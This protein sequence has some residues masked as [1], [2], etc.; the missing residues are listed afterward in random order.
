NVSKF[1]RRAENGEMTIDW[2][3]M[4]RVVR[5]AVRFLDDVIEM[6]P[7][8]LP[9]I[10]K[11]VKDNRRI[12]LGI[13]GWADLLFLLGIPYDGKA[14]TDL[15]DRLMSFV[16]GSRT[17]SRPSSPRNAGRSRTGSI[18]STRTSGR[19]GTPPSPRSR[20]PARSR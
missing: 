20:P 2:D 14:A 10:D 13:M 11:T 19:C 5:L 12:G 4:E 15:A 17:T 1:A 3:E 16:K 18:R 6:N 8:P 7:Y 9:V